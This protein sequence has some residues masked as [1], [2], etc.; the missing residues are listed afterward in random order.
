VGKEMAAQVSSERRTALEPL[1]SAW[2][3]STNR[4]RSYDRQIERIAKEQHSGI[5]AL[6]QIGGVGTL[7]ALSYVPTLEDP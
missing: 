6:E 4:S 1:L 5:R 3:S 7:M 2:K